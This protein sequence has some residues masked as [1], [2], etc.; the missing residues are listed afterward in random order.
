MKITHVEPMVLEAPVKEPWRI[1]TA[2]YTS[3]HA[4]VVR[5]DTDE[6]ISGWGEGLVRFSPKAGAAITRDILAPVVV[7][8]DPR[9]IELLWDKMYAVMRGRGHSKGYV[10]EAISAVDIALWD[11]LGKALGQP[12]HRLLGSY[13]R[14]ALPVYASSILLKPV[15]E[16]VREAERLAAQGFTGMK[17]KIGQGVDADMRSVRAIR[18]ALGD[19]VQLMVDA[20]CAYDCLAALRLGR[21]LEA[22][23]VAWFEEPVGPEQIDSYAKLSQALDMPVAGGE[24][25][26][27]RWAFKE[28]LVR[29]AMDILQPDIGR[30]GGFSE[31]RKIAALASAFDVPVA[32]HTGACA[33]ILIAASI[34]WAASLGNMLTF[35]Y[36]YPENPLREALLVEPIPAPADSR[37][38]VLQGPGLGVEVDE[39]ALKRFRTA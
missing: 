35:E 39:R 17:L 9:D 5:V 2:L 19:G 6:G 23:G 24:T 34:Q 18:K 8:Q 16:Q 33:A 13:G 3:M 26:F 12:I 32:P 28:I 29:Q 21:Q 7:G 20:N 15:D 31:V 38:V 36:M 37:M 30:V 11:I 10:L 27:T 22:E 1:G 4:F 14:T 25:E